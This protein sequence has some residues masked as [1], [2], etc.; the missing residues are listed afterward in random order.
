[1]PALRLNETAREARRSAERCLDSWLSTDDSLAAGVML[2]FEIDE[3]GLIGPAWL[4]D[5]AEVPEGP[6]RC[7]ADAL[8]PLD[9]S[10]LVRHHL[11]PALRHGRREHTVRGS[12]GWPSP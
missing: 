11:A 9:W 6:L 1:V 10:G 2:G 5:R 4:Q 8:Y 12:P 7:F 3:R